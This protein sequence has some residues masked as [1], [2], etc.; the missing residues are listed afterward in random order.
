M[1]NKPRKRRA[2]STVITTVIILV[3][4]VVLGVGAI[5]FGTSLFETN[6]QQES[7]ATTGINLWVLDE[8]GDTEANDG[9][10]WGVAKVRNDG[11]THI[12]IDKIKVRSTEVPFTQ[13]YADT[14]ISTEVF[15]QPLNFTGWGT[16][17]F[18]ENSLG[19][20]NG[21]TLQI[22]TIGGGEVCA[23]S[24][25]GPVALS[26]GQ[27]GIVYFKLTNGTITSIDSGDSV[28]VSILADKAIAL[29]SVNVQGKK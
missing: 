19:V 14:T 18:L 11:D 4:S 2:I 17:G 25:S 29:Q 16:N 20:C 8:V 21:E 22:Q 15:L 5:N 7:V 28:S 1:K 23:D 3:A 9:L 12:A 6:A 27:V 10:S 24:A 26:P 13:W